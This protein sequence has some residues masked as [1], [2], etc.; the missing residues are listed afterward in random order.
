[1]RFQ[2]DKQKLAE[3]HA[4]VRNV[5]KFRTF[6]LKHLK[7]EKIRTLIWGLISAEMILY[8]LFGAGTAII[9]FAT[10][11]ILQALIDVEPMIAHTISTILA[12]LFAYITNRIFVFK[13][14]KLGFKE[15]FFEFLKFSEARIGTYFMTLVILFVD[16]LTFNHPK[17]AKMIGLVL[18]IILNY[19]FSKLFIFSKK[20]TKEDEKD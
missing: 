15:L 8:M 10:F 1:M 7:N 16:K 13:S 17:T 3:N 4:F 5:I 14:P 19:I 9:D 2:V 12:I 6:L 20:E 18:T 11:A